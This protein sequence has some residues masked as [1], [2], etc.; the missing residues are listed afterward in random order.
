MQD[1]TGRREHEQ[2]RLE[3]EIGKQ[4]L[5]TQATIDGQEKERKEIGKELHDNIGQQLTTTKLYLD[6][7][8]NTADDTTLEM[9]NLS[10]RSISDVINDLR[11]MSHSLVPPSLGDLGLVESVYELIESIR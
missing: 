9:V 6:L 5:L 4:K 8:K 10:L 1:I 11:T 7:A 2:R 3:Q